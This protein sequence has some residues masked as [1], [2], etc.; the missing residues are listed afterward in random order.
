MSPSSGM[1]QAPTSSWMRFQLPP[2]ISPLF[3]YPP[4]VA[5]F[6][7]RDDRGGVPFLLLFSCVFATLLLAML[8]LNV[9]GCDTIA[10]ATLHR[11]KQGTTTSS[12]F[13]SYYWRSALILFA[14]SDHNH[15]RIYNK[16]CCFLQ[17]VLKGHRLADQH[18]VFSFAHQ[19]SIKKCL[20]LVQ[21]WIR[22]IS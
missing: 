7:T 8:T 17:I 9:F 22:L 16:T 20:G 4:F 3:I 15:I 5:G 19:S 10:S 2:F 13:Q 18:F 1:Y 6:G 12:R 11:T 21:D 14:G